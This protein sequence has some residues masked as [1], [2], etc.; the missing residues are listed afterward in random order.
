[1]TKKALE[2]LEFLDG[3]K[4]LSQTE[5]AYMKVIWKHPRGISSEDLYSRF[6][7]PAGTKSTILFRNSE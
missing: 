6:Q 4:P 5:L 3:R 2:P 1:M 7:N